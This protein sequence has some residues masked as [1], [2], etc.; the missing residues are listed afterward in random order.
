MLNDFTDTMHYH[1][2]AIRDGLKASIKRL[3]KAKAH[4]PLPLTTNKN[5]MMHQDWV[6]PSGSMEFRK[7]GLSHVSM[8]T[9]S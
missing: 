6:A 1:S 2:R 8:K 7:A 4:I 3:D 5:I 9:S